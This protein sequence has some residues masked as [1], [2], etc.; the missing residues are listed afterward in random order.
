MKNQNIEPAKITKPIQLLAA[1]LVGLVLLDGSFLTAANSISS[2]TWASGL[3]V[4]AA[5]M[6]VPLFLAA[7]FLL[8]TK[9]RPEMQEDEFYSRY[10]HHR[11]ST[12]TGTKELVISPPQE[13]PKYIQIASRDED[14]TQV[15]VNDMLTNYA[16]VRESLKKAD[17]KINNIFGSTSEEPEVPPHLLLTLGRKVDLHK[18]QKLIKSLEDK[19]EYISLVPDGWE[20]NTI[21]V[22]SYSYRENNFSKNIQWS[23]EIKD[24]LLDTELTHE[25]LKQILE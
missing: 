21:Y 13:E 3:L 25:K 12:Q 5:V 18:L 22:G 16:E 10:L 24:Q 14:I 17:I 1:W 15:M 2:P 20:T 7:I 8:Q 6:N 9:F 19:I 11:Y 23:Q 4:I